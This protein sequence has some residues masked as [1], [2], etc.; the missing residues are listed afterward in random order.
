M[1]IAKRYIVYRRRAANR[2]G[3]HSPFVYD[4]IEKVFREKQWENKAAIKVLRKDL[5]KDHSM[6][7]VEDMGAGSRIDNNRLRKISKIAKVSS[8][9]LHKAA[10]LQRLVDF[11]GYKTILELGT[12]LGLTTAILASAKA[13]PRI[14]SLEGAPNLAAIAVKN[15]EKLNLKAEIITGSFEDNLDLAIDKLASVDFAYLDGNHQED[16]TMAYF[17]TIIPHTH[18][19]SVIIIGDIHWSLGMEKAW[20]S[21]KEIPDVRVTIDLF[22]MGLVFFRKEMTPEHFIIHYT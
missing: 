14:V 5:L 6:V 17:K 11:L 21:I 20:E 8:T 2:H 13:K 16:A 9:P 15:L 12:N 18:N 4:L 1:S 3:V 7:E 10:M 19:N 22:D